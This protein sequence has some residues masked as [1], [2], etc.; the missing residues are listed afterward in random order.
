[1]DRNDSEGAP[2]R[3]AAEHAL[4]RQP[5]RGAPKRAEIAHS[6]PRA[7]SGACQG[8]TRRLAQFINEKLIN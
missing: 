2:R 1:M 3:P 5:A 4:S 6:A 8:K 7:A